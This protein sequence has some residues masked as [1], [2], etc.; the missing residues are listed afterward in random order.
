MKTSYLTIALLVSATLARAQ[1]AGTAA[2]TA[3]QSA[4]PPPTPYSVVTNDANSRVWE[5]TVYEQATN[6]TVVARKHRFTEL[7]SG[8]NF[9]DPGTGQWRP[10][11]AAISLLPAGGAFAAEATSCQHQ[12]RFPLDISTGLIQLSTA[13]G[14][15]L[16]SRPVGLFFEDDNNSALI[17]ILSNSVGELVGSNQ[18]VYPDAFEGVAASVRYRYTLTGFEQDI[19]IQGNLPDPTALGLNP[20]RTRLGVLTAFFD[21]NN[22]VVTSGPVDA[23]D[24]LSDA[25][26]S[27]GSVK[28][29]QGRAFSIGNTEPSPPPAGVTPA[30]LLNWITNATQQ[31]SS[32]G[33]PTY[34]RWFQLN[35]RN[36][37][38]EEV[39]YRRVA[40]Q[41]SQLPPMTGRLNAV[42]TNLLAANSFLA[43]IPAR[44]LSPSASGEPVQTQAMQLSKLDLDQTRAVVL[45]Y[46]T[47][48]NDYEVD[49]DFQEGVT[50]LVSG[51]CFLHDITIEG[52]AVIKYANVNSVTPTQ[53]GA[54][55]YVTACLEVLGSVTCQTSSDNPA[56]FTAVDDNDITAGAQLPYPISSGIAALIAARNADVNQLSK[57]AA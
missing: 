46:V 23:A 44:L 28:M 31:A 52:G 53:L 36:Y 16:R 9:R 13:N 12:A 45:D 55:D 20:A 17:A 8:L 18:V 41:L 1:A 54:S 49:Y 24:G 30:T 56:I 26:L 40:A 21:T 5:R 14:L 19:V 29:A 10:S 37:L 42:S 22:P 25:T 32:K 50:Y 39:P 34:K 47:V 2:S 7:A 48:I 11:I 43:A 4:L 51:P 27:F 6:G 3:V 35:G 38:M 33:T 57:I 15:Q